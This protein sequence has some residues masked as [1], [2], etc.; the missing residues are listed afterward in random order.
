MLPALL[1]SVSLLAQSEP[2]PSAAVTSPAAG[3]DRSLAHIIQGNYD[4]ALRQLEGAATK[5]SA[6]AEVENLRGLALLLSGET[7][8]ALKSFDKALELNPKLLEARFNRALAMLRSNDPAKAISDLAKVWSAE[9]STLRAEA[10]YHTGIASDRL[11]R[12]AD[13]EK[14]LAKAMEVNPKLD[15]ALLYIGALRERR[16]DLQGAGRA[17]QDYLTAHPDSTLGL[18]RFGMAAHKAGRVDVAKRYLD[19]VIK[20]APDSPEAI[21]ARKFLVMWD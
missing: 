4:A 10:A 20:A 1:L 18:L 8:K 7:A 15:G 3:C 14:W 13:A 19:R 21:E 6:P 2:A 11:G 16:G 12:T 17:Y 5:G 9:G